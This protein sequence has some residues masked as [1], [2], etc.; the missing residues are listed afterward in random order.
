MN[1]P[2][3]NIAQLVAAFIQRYGIAPNTLLVGPD[4]PKDLIRAQLVMGLRIKLC[5]DISIQVALL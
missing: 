4:Q 5:D 2:V 1:I 3:S